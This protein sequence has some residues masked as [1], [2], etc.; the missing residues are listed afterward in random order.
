M[1]AAWDCEDIRSL[2]FK[3]LQLQD[4]ARLART[5]KGLFD[6][7]TDE[8]WRTATSLSPLLS[9]LPSDARRRPLRVENI[10]RLDVYAAKIKKLILENKCPGSKCASTQL[11]PEYN[12]ARRANR[13]GREGKLW[14]A[15]WSEIAEL[16]PSTEFLPN[17]HYIRFVY[18][19]EALL[20]PL[21]GISGAN[22]EHIYIK[23][24][25]NPEP[26]SVVRQFLE[27]LRETPKLG[28]IFVQDGEQLIPPRLIHQAPIQTLRLDPRNLRPGEGDQIL[29]PPELLSSSMS[30]LEHFTLG[31]T[32]GWYT[33]EL[34]KFLERKY[35]P[36]LKSLWLNLVNIRSQPC[37]PSCKK[38]EPGSWFCIHQPTDGTVG[39]SKR[40]PTIFLDGLNHPNLKLLRINFPQE[41]N[42]QLLLDVVKAA[43][44]S[45][46]LRDLTELALSGG[47]S[48][49]DKLGR[50]YNE[51]RLHFIDCK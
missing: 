10:Q 14:G 17:L 18:A 1:H 2:L 39:Q 11:P 20:V 41:A 38:R 32:P 46:Q 34:D 3:D 7:A 35:M 50:R 30:R 37:H 15:L 44:N 4:L 43:K 29:L 48:I 6:P 12:L 21:V 8:L 27:Q 42:G 36:G 33:P 31:L 45:C 47:N 28:Y 19:S 24:V 22:L 9:L 26:E 16:R 5:C 25:Q 51:A 13:T 23:S 40:S 49:I